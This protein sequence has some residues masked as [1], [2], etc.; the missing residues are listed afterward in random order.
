MMAQSKLAEIAFNC[1][2][3]EYHHPWTKSCACAAAGMLLS[4]IPFSLRT[5]ATVYVVSNRGFLRLK[6][7]R[8][9]HL[10]QVLY[11]YIAKG[12]DT[13]F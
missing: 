1:T 8:I 12:G 5:Y 7:S 11:M 13:K 9:S 2:C 6:I 4:E 10:L 3:Y